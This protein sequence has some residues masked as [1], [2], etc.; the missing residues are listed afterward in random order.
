MIDGMILDSGQDIGEP[1]AGID[2]FFSTHGKEGIDHAGTGSGFVATG[3]QIV[4]FLSRL[5]FLGWEDDRI[6]GNECSKGPANCLGATSSNNPSI[7]KSYK[8]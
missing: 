2:F 5:R 7:L 1:F 3:E 6:S 8:S 4:L